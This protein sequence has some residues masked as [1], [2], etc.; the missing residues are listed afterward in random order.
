MKTNATNRPGSR[1]TKRRLELAVLI[2]CC[3]AFGYGF[4]VFPISNAGEPSAEI[5]PVEPSASINDFSKFQHSSPQHTRMPC[6][7]CHV[8]R[9]GLTTPKMPGHTTCAACHAQEFIGNTSPMC[10]ICH[11]TTSVKPFP[12][13]RSFNITFDHGRHMQ[14]TNCATCHKSNRRGIGFSV[15]STVSAHITC[16]QCHGPRTE[17]GGRNIGSCGTCHQ[18]GR[19]VRVSDSAKA[20]SKNFSHQSH[21]RAGNTDC[22]TCHTVR[23]GGARGRQV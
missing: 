7:L 16:F 23:T 2:L 10:T 12:A 4:T 3:V 8:R 13:L 14:Q 22:A 1:T 9:E 11:T 17:I 6:L 21:I 20:Y 19:P 18:Q 5:A 15:P